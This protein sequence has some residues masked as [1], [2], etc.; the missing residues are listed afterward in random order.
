VSAN[1]SVWKQ[2]PDGELEYVPVQTGISDGTATELFSGSLSEGEEVIIGIEQTGGERKGSDLPP[3]FG[4][5][6]QRRSR[7]RGM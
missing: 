4:S 2:G 5:G 6:A 1:R 3:G 7:N